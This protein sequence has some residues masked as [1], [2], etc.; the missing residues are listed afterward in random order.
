[1]HQRLK[2]LSLHLPGRTEHNHGHV[3]QSAIFHVTTALFFLI[4]SNLETY[5]LQYLTVF[6]NNGNVCPTDTRQRPR[7]E[8]SN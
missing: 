1:M 5:R 6:R 7:N 3:T 4:F 2:I 8:F